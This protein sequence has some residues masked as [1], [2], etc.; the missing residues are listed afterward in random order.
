MPFYVLDFTSNFSEHLLEVR[1][2][3]KHYYFNQIKLV[4]TDTICIN[5]L[6]IQPVGSIDNYQLREIHRDSH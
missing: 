1:G 3:W 2:N 4:G 6:Y 5:K